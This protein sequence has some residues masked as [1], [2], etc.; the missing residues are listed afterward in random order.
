MNNWKEINASSPFRWNCLPYH[1]V[2][3]LAQQR[4]PTVR[5]YIVSIGMLRTPVPQ[6]FS[7]GIR[8][9]SI[10]I[11]WTI[12]HGSLNNNEN[13]ILFLFLFCF[14]NEMKTFRMSW[15][16]YTLA[17]ITVQITRVTF[18]YFIVTFQAW[19]GGPP[20]NETNYV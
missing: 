10:V 5:K 9:I 4:V 20:R 1:W 11:H 18:R 15:C 16:L 3:Q 14:W 12:S 6:A 19:G 2:L 17:F 13:F 7:Y 8:H